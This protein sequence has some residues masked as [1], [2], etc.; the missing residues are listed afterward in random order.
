MCVFVC[1]Y[2]CI[3]SNRFVLVP[4]RAYCADEAAA[5]TGGCSTAIRSATAKTFARLIGVNNNWGKCLVEW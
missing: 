3:C 1:M 5:I 2:H 4:P